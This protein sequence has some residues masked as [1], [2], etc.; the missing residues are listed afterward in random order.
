MRYIAAGILVLFFAGVMYALISNEERRIGGQSRPV[1][2]QKSENAANI[3][4]CL[5]KDGHFKILL[6]ALKDTELEMTLSSKENYTFLAPTDEAFD[7]VPKL[8]DLID[9]PER[10]TGVMEH[11]LLVGT[12]MDTSALFYAEVLH[13][14]SGEPL[15]VTCNDRLFQ[16]DDAKI[17]IEDLQASNGYVHGIDRVLM[18]ENDSMLRNAGETIERG[19]KKG[20]EKIKDT[21]KDLN[22]A[23]PA[24]DE[25]KTLDQK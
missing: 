17:R 23:K 7:R 1:S 18:K 15:K 12:A 13:P 11:H 6:S 4:E 2:E 10:F 14:K 24:K 3:L 9:S 8:A 20:T 22:R 16:V 5:R 25:A 21:F 19:L